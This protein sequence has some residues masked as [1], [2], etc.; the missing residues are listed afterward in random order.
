VLVGALASCLLLVVCVGLIGG[1]FYFFNSGINPLISFNTP[2]SL[3]R[4]VYVGTDSNIYV[5]DPA[6]GAA[7]ALTTDGGAEH[8]YNYPTWSPDSRRLAFVG[9]TFDNGTPKEGA[10]YTVSPNGEKLTPVYKTSQNFPFYLYWSPD[11]QIISFLANNDS[12]SIALRVARTDEEDSMQE[13][14]AGAPFYWAWAPDGSKMFTHVGG[15]RQENDDARLALL[16]FNANGTPESLEALPGQFQAPQ[17]SRNGKLLYSQQ[18]GAQQAIALGDALGQE[19]QKLA[20]YPGRASFALSPDASHV[21]YLLT[22]TQIRLP[23]FGLLRVM[24]ANGENV[25]VVAQEPALAFLWSPDSTKLA[26]LTVSLDEN[27]SNFKIGSPPRLA[28]LGPLTGS[29]AP[30][31]YQGGEQAI[32]LNWRVWDRAGESS[33]TIASFAPTVSFLNVI[34]YFDQYANSS[35]YW[36]PDSQSLVYT[37]RESGTGGSVFVA[38]VSGNSPPRKIGDGVIAYWSWK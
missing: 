12:S 3:N 9:Y 32:Q 31:L 8:A 18:D 13:V 14:D 20:T 23:H 6:S 37:S 25:R 26:F 19:T 29:P 16:P 22:D 27:Q 36:S 1:G 5:A 24:D 28:G 33:R 17:W 34:P 15:T 38:D 11:S 30:N 21:A 2:S 4:I 7:T 35:T 10:L